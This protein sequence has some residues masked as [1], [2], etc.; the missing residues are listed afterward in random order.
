MR[1]EWRMLPLGDSH[2]LGEQQDITDPDAAMLV[3]HG[4]TRGQLV[5]C[6]WQTT[7]ELTRR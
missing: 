7:Y 1:P 4:K 5:P 3:D 6:E 2:V